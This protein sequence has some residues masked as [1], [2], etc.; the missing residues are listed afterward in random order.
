VLDL[1]TQLCYAAAVS[2]Y[3]GAEGEMFSLKLC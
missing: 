2:F 3:W 1:Y